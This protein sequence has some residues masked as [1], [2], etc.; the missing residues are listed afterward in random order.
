MSA[1]TRGKPVVLAP[2]K[3]GRARRLPER[4][5][6]EPEVAAPMPRILESPLE[7]LTPSQLSA[8]TSLMVPLK[9]EIQCLRA[10][11]QRYKTFAP[12]IDIN[13]GGDPAL[14]AAE[15]S[16]RKWLS[17]FVA[18]LSE[19][20]TCRDMHEAVMHL[21]G[22]EAAYYDAWRRQYFLQCFAQQRDYWKLA[23]ELSQELDA[24]NR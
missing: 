24:I 16:S 13:L 7:P 15:V 17:H 12:G 1:F 3:R 11:L 6:H 18:Q 14:T 2:S 19:M 10:E 9:K 4:L 8:V 22:Q 20:K 21:S 5:K 23:S